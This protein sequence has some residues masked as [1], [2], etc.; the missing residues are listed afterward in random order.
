MICRN[1]SYEVSVAEPLVM[2]ALV[3]HQYRVLAKIAED[4]ARAFGRAADPHRGSRRRFCFVC[5]V[6]VLRNG[7]FT[8]APV[9]RARLPPP[10][11]AAVG[12]D[13]FVLGRAPESL[14]DPSVR[15]SG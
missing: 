15:K 1:G 13:V 9:A 5:F 8:A 10:C 12:V 11:A 6:C 2:E 14:K 7:L 4:P 3:A